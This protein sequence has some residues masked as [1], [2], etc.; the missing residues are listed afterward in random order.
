MTLDQTSDAAQQW[1]IS[2]L[3][4]MGI[5]AEV[6]LETPEITD[7]CQGFGGI[8]L[9]IQSEGLSEQSVE[10]LMGD[11]GQHLDAIQTLLNLTMNLDLEEDARQTYT[12]ELNGFRAK[13]YV[14]LAEMATE[15]ASKVRASNEEHEM[16]PM[17][18]AE[19]RL[20]HTLFVDD[21]DLATFS[22]GQ[23]RDRRLI[24]CS[25]EAKPE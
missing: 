12:L 23:D 3:Q 18:A 15:A 2:L 22:R 10:Q 24:V 19:R 8:W 25:S 17:S 5:D 14:E 20:V 1:L 16:P 9:T 11:R 7:K 21:K 13:R 4:Q 6:S